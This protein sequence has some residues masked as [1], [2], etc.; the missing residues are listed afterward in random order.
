[1]ILTFHVPPLARGLGDYIISIVY[2]PEK[3]WRSRHGEIRP[4]IRVFPSDLI[5]PCKDHPFFDL[6][7]GFKQSI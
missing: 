1:M 3:I 5:P 6:F 7:L 4:I 2:S